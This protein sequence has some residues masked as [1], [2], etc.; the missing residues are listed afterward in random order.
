MP[1]SNPLVSSLLEDVRGTCMELQA[2][3]ALSRLASAL[4]VLCFNL[5]SCDL[6]VR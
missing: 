5:S 1:L 2:P 3:L 4:L 6:M